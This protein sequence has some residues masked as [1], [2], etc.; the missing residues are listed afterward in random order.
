MFRALEHTRVL[1]NS[2]DLIPATAARERDTVTA[3]A[4]ERIDQDLIVFGR[5][6]RYVFCDFTVVVVRYVIRE[7]IVNDQGERR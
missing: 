1:L 3:R 7:E 6:I 5:G 2:K 4:G